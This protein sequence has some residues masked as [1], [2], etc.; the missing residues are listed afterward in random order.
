MSTV[1]HGPWPATG[2]HLVQRPDIFQREPPHPQ[3]PNLP[4]GP[5]HP[6][7]T[8]WHSW[9]PRA[10]APRCRSA[11]CQ[12]LCPTSLPIQGG[13]GAP[14]VR[15]GEASTQGEAEMKDGV[16][17]GGHISSKPLKPPEP[18]PVRSCSAWRVPVALTSPATQRVLATEP[19]LL[20]MGATHCPFR[21]CGT[22]HG[23]TC[24]LNA[25]C[26]LCPRT[27]VPSA[28]AFPSARTPPGL[29]RS[30]ASEALP[31]PSLLRG[32]CCPSQHI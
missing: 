13:G 22:Q 16:G 12:G 9:L 18:E 5:T 2:T 7:A 26:L 4:C 11:A 6:G 25:P 20:A 31:S 10:P 21:P 28:E 17:G 3:G 27:G 23:L 32:S 19:E 30:P 14:A 29:P 8:T 15:E 1:L 24:S